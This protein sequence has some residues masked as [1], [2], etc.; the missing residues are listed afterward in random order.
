MT[1]TDIDLMAAGALPLLRPFGKAN[2]G[3]SPGSI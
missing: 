1:A 3:L 2:P